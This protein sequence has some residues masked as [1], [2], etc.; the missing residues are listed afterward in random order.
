MHILSPLASAWGPATNRVPLEPG[1]ST[2]WAVPPGTH[3]LT[4]TGYPP[5]SIV[6]GTNTVRV[7]VAIDETGPGLVVTSST[8]TPTPSPEPIQV[9]GVFW[10]GFALVFGPGAIFL[11]A[12]KP[13][14]KI[15]VD[16]M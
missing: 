15:A 6:V 16:G 14:R 7:T 8:D 4:V 12:I 3:S 9:S 2:V 1:N 10:R 13:W 11:L 5:A